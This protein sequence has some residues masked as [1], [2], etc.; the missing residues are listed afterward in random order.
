MLILSFMK[1]TEFYQQHLYRFCC[2]LGVTLEHLTVLSLDL[3][4]I[5]VVNIRCSEI[6]NVLFD[7]FL[8]LH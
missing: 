3:V 1:V 5:Y 4:F 8:S 7:R 2:L 6:S